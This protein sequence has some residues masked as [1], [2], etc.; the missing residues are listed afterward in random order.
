MSKNF[1]FFV[2]I[3]SLSLMA[4]RKKPLP[5]EP[6]QTPPSATTG[7]MRIQVN[8]MVGN[9]GLAVGGLVQH[10]LSN[11]ESFTVNTYDYYLSNFVF[12][13]EKGN[14]F[15]EPESY[16]LL[17]AQDPSSLQLNF[18][19]IPIAKYKTVEFVIGVDSTRNFSGAQIGALDPK[20]G[21]FWTWSTGYI[22][23]R[24]EGTSPQSSDANKAIAYH[25]GGFRNLFNV[26]R[27]VKLELPEMAAVSA[28]STPI[29]DMNA[30]VA[31]WFTYIGFSNF[32]FSKWPL[33]T[34]EGEEAFHIANNY[35]TMFS[36]NSVKN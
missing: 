13:D 3:T 18:K 34:T 30:D 7:S 5:V 16:Y 4:C 12:T 15:V 19:N 28:Q 31:K 26:I 36:I 25:I 27:K 2:I 21:M 10:T 33:V 24:L 8:N 35:A 17:R 14:K 32:S 20:Y 23:A 9:K 29:I 11:G 6:P 22:M 1:A